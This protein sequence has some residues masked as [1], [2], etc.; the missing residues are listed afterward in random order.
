[1]CRTRYQ[2]AARGRERCDAPV[3]RA[4]LGK[5]MRA[6][7]RTALGLSIWSMPTTCDRGHIVTGPLMNPRA[8]AKQR[9]VKRTQDSYL[10]ATIPP[11][12]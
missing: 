2:Y 4:H 10:V 12:G 8:H 1:M 7:R 6:A 3:A 9:A 5:S 11:K